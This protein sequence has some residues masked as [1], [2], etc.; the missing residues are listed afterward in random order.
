MFPWCRADDKC[1]NT[2]IGGGQDNTGFVPDDLRDS[3]SK[4]AKE[5]QR[6]VKLNVFTQ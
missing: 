5:Q 3:T 1:Q 6:K 2:E 4:G